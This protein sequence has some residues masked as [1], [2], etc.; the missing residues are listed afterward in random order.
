MT[1]EDYSNYTGLR[2][3]TLETVGCQVL[4]VP[5]PSQIVLQAGPLRSLWT[6]DEAQNFDYGKDRGLERVAETR[7][8]PIKAWR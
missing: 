5:S 4:S 7:V 2:F 8:Y 3:P 1:L 6:L